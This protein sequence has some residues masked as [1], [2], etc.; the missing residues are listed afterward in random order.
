[1]RGHGLGH[2]DEPQRK[3]RDRGH[4]AQVAERRLARFCDLL[5]CQNREEM[6]DIARFG[7]RPRLGVHYVGNGISLKGFKPRLTAPQNPRPVIVFVGRL[8][9]VKNHAMLF[10]A[11]EL[12]GGRYNPVV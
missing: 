12:I 7:I 1:M 10:D 4:Q 5:L 3:S 11:L 8:E 2:P 9:P 6:L